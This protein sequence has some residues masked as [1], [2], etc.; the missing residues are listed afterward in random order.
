MS[1]TTLPP[2][3]APAVSVSNV[4]LEAGATVSG[5]GIAAAAIAPLVVGQTMPTTTAGWIA[6]II[7]IATALLKVFGK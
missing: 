3:T 1:D 6:E 2:I 7:A 4:W 5:I